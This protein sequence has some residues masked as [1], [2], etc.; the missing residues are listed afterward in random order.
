MGMKDFDYKQFLLEKGE[1][2]GLGVAAA[3]GALLIVFGL[4]SG[5][6]GGSASGTQAQIDKERTSA[7]NRIDIA[8]PNPEDANK[9]QKELAAQVTFDEL[10]PSKFRPPYTYFTPSSIEDTKRRN[11]EI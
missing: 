2:V 3:F 11:P 9:D 4:V 7:K 8:A 1:R 5:L 10:D 6:S